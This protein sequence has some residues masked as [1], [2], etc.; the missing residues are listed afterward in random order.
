[1]KESPPI[2]D[3]VLRRLQVDLPDYALTAWLR[4]LSAEGDASGLWLL[5]PLIDYDRL[6]ADSSLGLLWQL[7]TY[8]RRGEEVEARFTLSSIS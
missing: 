1:M 2:W 4:P 7:F 8:A 5:W 3:G 6:A